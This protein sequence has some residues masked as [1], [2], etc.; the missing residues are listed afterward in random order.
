MWRIFL[1]VSLLCWSADG[2]DVTCRDNNNGEVDWYIMYKAPKLNNI[3]TKGLEYIYIDPKGKKTSKDHNKLINNTN[4]VLAN[5]LRPLFKPT[6]SMP[7]DFGFISYSDQPPDGK[8]VPDKFGHSKGLVMMDKAKTGVWL[9]HSV[10]K[11]P[12]KRDNNFYP[13]SGSVYAQT[14]ICVTF[15]YNQFNKI[16]QHLL[17]I[18]AYPFDHHIPT[19]FYNELK[20][21]A[22]KSSGNRIPGEIIQHLTSAGGTQFRSFAKKLY[23][24][25]RPQQGIYEGDLYL[26]IAKEYNTDVKV[27]TWPCNQDKP[28]CEQNQPQVI[29]I[30]SVKA[31]LGNGEVK[32]E[33][34]WKAGNDHAKWCVAKDNNNHLICIADVNRALKQY[35]R[36]GGALCFNHQQVSELFKGLINQTED[37]SSKLPRVWDP[38]CDPDAGS[39]SGGINKPLP[40]SPV[41]FGP[42][43]ALIYHFQM[44]IN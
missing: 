12:F 6:T 25:E 10:P 41:L 24:E 8:G 30:K 3:G 38:D 35:T 4:G 13:T 17:N 28:Y 33:V 32:W 44:I 19:D 1:M 40:L 22:N 39:L 42:L 5:T 16:G 27:Q 15:N 26:T 20:E 18:S 36:P 7:A 29:N 11:F 21:A 34:E 14:F 2:Q 23:K 37:C 9:L 43:C 31:D